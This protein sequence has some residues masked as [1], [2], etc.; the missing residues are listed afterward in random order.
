MLTLLQCYPQAANQTFEWCYKNFYDRFSTGKNKPFAIAETGAFG[1]LREPW[2]KEL[3]GQSK[4]D[5]P[6]YCS[7]SWFEYDKGVDFR[8]VMGNNTILADTKRELGLNQ[9]W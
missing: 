6:N 3:V 4:E 8:L 2:L 1:D 5:Y 7:V 9:G